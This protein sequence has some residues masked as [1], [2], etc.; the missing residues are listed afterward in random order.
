[1]D[2]ITRRLANKKSRIEP[3]SAIDPRKFAHSQLSP[4]DDAY[5]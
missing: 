4:D 5:L 3:I 1:M 2:V